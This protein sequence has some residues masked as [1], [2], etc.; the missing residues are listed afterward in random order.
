MKKIFAVI[1]I[2]TMLFSLAACSEEV[3]SK[4]SSASAT[5]EE[6]ITGALYADF[7][8]GNTIDDRVKG[9]S[10]EYSEELNVSGLANRLSE[11]TGL[12]FKISFSNTKDGLKIDWKKDST[13]VSGL[14]DR[15][16][17]EDFTF[18]DSDTMRWFM[19]DTLWRTLTVNLSVENIYYTMD[20]GKE[21]SFEELLPINV[22]PAD[23]P[24]MGS[25][26]YF[27]HSDLKGEDSKN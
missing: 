18:S 7:S 13:L 12:D 22:F 2:L 10:F 8:Y 15:K 6:M 1:L 14:D 16:Q 21:L 24:Y 9:Y 4:T 23:V 26:F 20:G 27:A 19:M 3:S 25:G 5:K 17:K 11:L